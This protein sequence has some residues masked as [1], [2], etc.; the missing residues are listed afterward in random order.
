[1]Q[2]LEEAAGAEAEGA[3]DDLAV[4]EGEAADLCD[5]ADIE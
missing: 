5:P 1:M 4:I 3:M 2:R